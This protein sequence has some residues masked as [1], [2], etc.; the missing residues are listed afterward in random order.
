M[1]NDTLVEIEITHYLTAIT[2]KL[3]ISIN[4]SQS[5]LK[6]RLNSATPTTKLCNRARGDDRK[7]ITDAK[8]SW[9]KAYPKERSKYLS[10]YVIKLYLSLYTFPKP[11]SPNLRYNT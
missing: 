10:S 8:D 5:A 11:L 4:L 7:C 9:E 6:L 1:P 3:P 2:R